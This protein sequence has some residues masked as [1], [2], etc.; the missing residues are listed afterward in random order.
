MRARAVTRHSREPELALDQSD[1]EVLVVQ[2]QQGV[3]RIVWPPA[4]AE[5]ELSL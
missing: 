2:W 5:T 3:K 4:L 1:H